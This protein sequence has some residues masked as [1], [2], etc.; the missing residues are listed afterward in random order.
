MDRYKLINI[1]KKIWRCT[2]RTI[3][4]ILVGSVI[5]YFLIDLIDSRNPR[6]EGK[7]IDTEFF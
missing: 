6:F 3:L 5:L 2:I 1:S 7:D 4:F